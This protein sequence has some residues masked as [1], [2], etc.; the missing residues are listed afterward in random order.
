MDQADKEKGSAAPS[1]D[2]TG[3]TAEGGKGGLQKLKDP[4]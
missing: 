3:S 4:N 2:G 1:G